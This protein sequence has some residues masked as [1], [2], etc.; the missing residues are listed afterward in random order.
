MSRLLEPLVERLLA[1]EHV[2]L[3]GPRGLGKSRLL[4]AVR[5]TLVARGRACAASAATASLGHVRE[6]LGRGPRPSVL[7]LDH[8]TTVTAPMK[9]ALRTLRGGDLGVLFA[10]DV[11]H[12][13][14]HARLRRWCLSNHEVAMPTTRSGALRRLLAGRLAALD[15]E[16]ERALLLAARGRP[17]LVVVAAALARDPSYWRGDRLHVATLTCDAELRLRGALP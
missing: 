12:P 11:D 4:A 8:V 13:R 3:H 7:L 9:T 14:E 17:G 10:V 15:A 6:A 2:V 1:G 16:Q 5:T